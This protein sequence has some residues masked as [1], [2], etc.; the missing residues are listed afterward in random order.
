MTYKPTDIK[1]PFFSRGCCSIP[2][3]NDKEPTAF[4]NSCAKLVT[5]NW[6]K[7]FPLPAQSKPFDCIEVRFKNNRKDFYRLPYNM[8]LRIGDIIAV[9]ASPG[10][11]IGI[12]SMTGMIVKMLMQRKNID[13]V[14]TDLKSVYRKAR[15]AD[16]EK[17]IATVELEDK[18]ILKTRQIVEDLRLGM[19]LNDV[20]YQGDGT[21]AIFFYTAEE[22]VDFR[23]LIR[24]LAERF[25]VRIEMR[26]IGVRQE[27]SR[28]GGIGSCGRELCCSEWLMGFSSVSTTAARVQQLTPNPQKLAGQC[29]KLKC[30]LNY[31]YS[32]YVD[33]L[34]HF[35]PN[36]IVLR[37]KKGEAIYQKSDVFKGLMWYSYTHDNSSLLAIPIEKVKFIIE[38]NNK[39]T[40]PDKLEDFANKKE[41]KIDYENTVGQ[42]DLHRFDNE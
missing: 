6:L 26:Q 12:V 41:K 9:E 18:A 19:K 29:A 23:E 42:D 16:I 25:K 30:C 35:P 21:K 33:A 13:P 3:S 5:T 10:H 14:R 39:R 24:I 31:E 7:N 1:N 8:E 27:A 4:K 17:W 2:H 40:L 36:N 22:R 15:P 32:A 28:L 37:T 34:K 38:E 20:E 11:D